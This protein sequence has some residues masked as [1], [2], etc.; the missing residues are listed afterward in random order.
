[1]RIEVAR[2]FF[3]AKLVR[4]KFNENPFSRSRVVTWVQTDGQGGFNQLSGRI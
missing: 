2:H 1:M 4:I 3:F